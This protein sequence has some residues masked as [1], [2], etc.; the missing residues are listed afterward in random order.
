MKKQAYLYSD[1]RSLN[2]ATLFYVGIVEDCLEQYGYSLKRVT[3]LSDIKKPN[4]IFT[5]THTYYCLAKL[6]HPFVKTIMWIQG[7]GIEEAKMNRAKWKWPLFYI[8]E[9][10]SVRKADFILFVSERMREYYASEFGYSG[11]N[12]VIM[13]CFNLLYN[14]KVD[15]SKFQKPNFVY[16]GGISTWQSIDKIL[17]VYAEIEKELP[18]AKLTM[19]CND[20]GYLKDEISKRGIQNFE[21][22]F[23]PLAE[24]QD[25][26]EKY[27]YG[28]IIREKNWVNEVAT[29][30]KMNSYLAAHIIP[31]YSDGVNDFERNIKLGEFTLMAKT[32]LNPEEISKAVVAFE[33][34]SHN[35]ESFIPLIKDVFD[36]HYNI[37]TYKLLISEKIK[38]LIANK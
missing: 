23:V 17:D 24:L 19:L 38:E 31:I 7:L 22:K 4:L 1:P 27:K 3:K 25:E 14:D 9:L 20:K 5:I 33:K 6:R 36:K 35:Y 28:F 18:E 29:P 30:T 21:I 2:E 26:L 16:A 13:P 34:E 15:Y 37:E 10:Y 32:P 12:Y 8:T 11:N